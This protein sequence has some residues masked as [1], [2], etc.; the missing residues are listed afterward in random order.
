MKAI[1]V[2]PLLV[3]IIFF[4]SCGIDGMAPR[5]RVVSSTTSSDGASSQPIT[6]PNSCYCTYEYRPVCGLKAGVPKTYSNPCAAGCD[7]L[8]EVTEGACPE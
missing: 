5:R 6:D 7:G 3:L 1:I 8:T 4:E 2:I